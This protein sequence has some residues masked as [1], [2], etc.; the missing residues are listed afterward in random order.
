MIFSKE[1][2]D[3]RYMVSST[4]VKIIY[5]LGLFASIAAE[6]FFLGTSLNS[7]TDSINGVS[8]SSVAIFWCSILATVVFNLLWRLICEGMVV[9]FSIHERLV[10]IEK[11]IEKGS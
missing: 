1:F 11:L 3:F 4:I 7:Y 9:T 6:A 2:F 8:L 10:S 5:I